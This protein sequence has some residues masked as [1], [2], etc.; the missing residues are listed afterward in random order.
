M[1]HLTT[2]EELAAFLSGINNA[3]LHAVI[4]GHMERLAEFEGYDLAEL[5]EFIIIEPADR[6]ADMEAA[7]GMEGETLT[8]EYCIDHGTW[9]E[10]VRILDD[11]G[12]GHVILV[13]KATPL[14]QHIRAA[15]RLAGE[16]TEM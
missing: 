15:C 3:T 6:P 14:P 4:T 11:T 13:P 9:Y 1:I 8:C 16:G 2:H 12:F 10:V 5:A 7:L